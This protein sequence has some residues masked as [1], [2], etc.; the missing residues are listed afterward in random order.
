MN[1]IGTLGWIA[2]VTVILLELLTMLVFLYQRT[3]R[4]LAHKLGIDQRILVFLYPKYMLLAYQISFLKWPLYVYLLFVN[5]VVAIGIFISTFVL[6]M[7]L[8]IEDRRHLLAMRRLL[9][10]CYADYHTRSSESLEESIRS[11]L[12]SETPFYI[13]NYET[14]LKAIDDGLVQTGYVLLNVQEYKFVNEFGMLSDEALA[15]LLVTEKHL[16]YDGHQASIH[17]AQ[18]RK[19]LALYKN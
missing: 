2:I 19:H 9:K 13:E 5:W 7:I 4:K 14:I 8:P 1:G 6:S 3:L 16:F 12:D 10:K 18:I 17:I 11:L 15:I